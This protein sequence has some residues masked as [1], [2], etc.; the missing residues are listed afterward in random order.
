MREKIWDIVKGIGIISIVIGHA[1]LTILNVHDFVY[2]YH[3][4]IFFFVSAYFYNEAK[5]GDEPTLNFAKRFKSNWLKD[6]FYS[7]ILILLHNFFVRYHFYNVAKYT[8]VKEYLEVFI[9]AMIFKN[10]ETFQGALWFIPALIISSGIFGMI[11][12]IARKISKVFKG[13]VELFIKYFT[14]IVL[15]SFIGIVGVYLNK[16]GMEFKY[17]LHTVFLVMPIYALGYFMKTYIEKIKKLKKWYIVIPTFVISTGMLLYIILKT[18]L[19]IEI[20]QEIIANGYMFYII[21]FIGICFCLSLASIIEKLPI[22]NIIIATIGKYSFAIMALNFAFIKAVDVVYC[23][24]INETN[25]EVISTWVCT[26]PNKLLLVYVLVGVGA[27]ALL[28]LIA[29]KIMSL[30]KQGRMEKEN[31][32]K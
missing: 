22:I 4:V 9:D 19:R 25:P 15:S 7:I 13:K 18:N 16:K 28:A 21:S 27:P 14:I 30:I 8:T 26:Y 3:I 20:S 11:V 6:L 24:M 31:G 12:Y 32:K 5:Y 2:L 1:G 17:Y 29:N 23:K 10:H